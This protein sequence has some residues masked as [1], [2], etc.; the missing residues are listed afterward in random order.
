MGRRV[1]CNSKAYLKRIE[2]ARRRMEEEERKRQRQGSRPPLSPVVVRRPPL[3]R[4]PV[5][6]D[7]YWTRR[8]ELC[9]ENLYKEQLSEPERCKCGWLWGGDPSMSPPSPE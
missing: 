2:K 4:T 9:R 3:D 5:L 6:F 8:C 1:D 7:G